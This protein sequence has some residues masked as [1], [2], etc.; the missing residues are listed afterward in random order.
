MNFKYK[1]ITSSILVV[2][3]ISGLYAVGKYNLNKTSENI[4]VMQDK[5]HSELPKG[6]TQKNIINNGLFKSVGVYKISYVNGEETENIVVNYVL[7]HGIIS[8]F[9]GNIQIEATSRLEG[10]MIKNVIVNGDLLNTTG[11]IFKDGSFDLKSH[12]ANVSILM[13]K[14]K[15][16][17]SINIV[18]SDSMINYNSK[19][20][21]VNTA[22]LLPNIAINGDNMGIVKNVDFKNI[23]INRD[24]NI[25]RITFG[26][27]DIAIGEIDSQYLKAK[28]LE[29]KTSVDVSNKKYNIS[30]G[31]KVNEIGLTQTRSPSQLEFSYSINNIDSD[32]IDS[33]VNLYNKYKK[34]G[35]LEETDGILIKENLIKII[36]AGGSVN[37]DRIKAKGPFGLVD[38]SG[39]FEII[40]VSDIS[41]V[42]FKNQSKIFFSV[43]VDGDLATMLTKPVVTNLLGID[44]PVDMNPSPSKFI[45]SMSYENNNLM[46][47]GITQNS[48][49]MYE[50]IKNSLDSADVMLGLNSDKQAGK[51]EFSDNNGN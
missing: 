14:D 37:I 48:S 41:K 3:G 44:T 7:K 22:L 28:G 27:L 11:T 51:E 17:S 24:F 15:D 49:L 13:N 32:E 34:F 47:N 20:G 8:F 2:L 5:L 12:S 31:I 42:S 43:N 16:N 30:T 39:K 9:T 35:K 1:I 26:N 33:Y 10:T 36:Q 25:N 6:V 4:K 19:S 23:K 46:V 29:L 45:M 21:D 40:P 50:K 18:P 38:M